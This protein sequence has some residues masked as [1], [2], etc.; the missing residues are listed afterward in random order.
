MK[1]NYNFFNEFNEII[2]NMKNSGV[3]IKGFRR[4]LNDHKIID[5]IIRNIKN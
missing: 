4:R 2:F 5:W 1:K 3:K